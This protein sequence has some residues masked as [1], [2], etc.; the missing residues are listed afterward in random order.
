ML[1]ALRT[2][3]AD[4][5]GVSSMIQF[6]VRSAVP[7][8]YFAFV[9]ASLNAVLPGSFSRWLLR[10]RRII[11]LC[12]AQAMAWQLVFIVWLVTKHTDYYLG[13]VYVFSDVVEGVPGYAFLLA[14]VLTS[15]S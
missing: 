4:A 7:F 14:M 2:D 15:F 10:N 13:E 6:S 11:G 5:E 9:A 12:F 3:L 8:L 1:N